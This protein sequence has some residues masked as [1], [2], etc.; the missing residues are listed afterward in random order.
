MEYPRIEFKLQS[1]VRKYG[2][3]IYKKFLFEQADVNKNRPKKKTI[4]A[5]ILVLNETKIKASDI[6]R[7]GNRIRTRNRVNKEEGVKAGVGILLRAK[8]RNNI[9]VGT[10]Q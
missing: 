10:S 1:Y 2:K 3:V 4:H 5:D 6:E 9:N 8:Y 7:I